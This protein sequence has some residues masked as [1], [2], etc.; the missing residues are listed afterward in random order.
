M[1]STP[2]HRRRTRSIATAAAAGVALL[3]GCRAEPPSPPAEA[4]PTV[5][6]AAGLDSPALEAPPDG[7]PTSPELAARIAD[8][9]ALPA[10][11]ESWVE[12]GRAWIRTARLAQREDLYRRAAAAADEALARAPGNREAQHLQALVHRVG[13]RFDEIRRIATALTSSDP[14]DAT[15][16]GLLADA[17]LELGDMPAAEQAVDRMLDLAPALPAFSRAAWLRWLHGDVD[18]A[19]EMWREAL[20][21]SGRAD[22]E[23]RAFVLTEIG[24]LQ[25]H[26]ARLDEAEEAYRLA[27]EALPRHAGALFGLGRVELARGDAAAAAAHLA[28]SNAARLSELTAEW[29]ALALRA[30]G[31]TAE[32]DALDGKLAAAGAFDD[33]RTVALYLNHRGIEPATAVTRARADFEQRRDVYSHDALGFALLRAGQLDEAAKHLE[34][35]TA[36]GTPDATLMAHRGL[37]E[38]AR[39]RDADARIWLDRAWTTNPHAHPR[40]MAEVAAARGAPATAQEPR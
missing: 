9:R 28:A 38:K 24:H 40:L 5:K 4:P 10:R 18:G 36:L 6:P 8:V 14:R 33:P 1:T 37:L 3:A 35:A 11:A 13:H 29:H 23:P 20:R 7:V 21:A 31:R 19:L 26:R 30:A 2:R 15:A 32:A 25:W 39:G 17:A 22:P 16:W 27:L 12:L 34:A